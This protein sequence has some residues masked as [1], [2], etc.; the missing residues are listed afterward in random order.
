[1]LYTHGC[2]NTFVKGKKI[3]SKP[4]CQWRLSPGWDY[5]CFLIFL[6]IYFPLLCFPIFQPY[7]KHDQKID[8]SLR[9]KMLVSGTVNEK[10]EFLLSYFCSFSLPSFYHPPPCSSAPLSF[11]VARGRA[12][13]SVKLRVVLSLCPCL[14]C[15]LP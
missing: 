1:M 9:L 11:T 4:V 13:V 12:D 8:S 2:I 6:F 5:G 15:S 7:N 3:N 14:S 10:T